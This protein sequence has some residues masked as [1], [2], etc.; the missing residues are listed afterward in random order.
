MIIQ[1]ELQRCAEKARWDVQDAEEWTRWLREIPTIQFPSYWFVRM[2]PPFNGAIVRFR[3]SLDGD[4]EHEAS[5][6]LD[7]YDRIGCFGAPYWEVYPYGDD[8]GRVAMTDVAG[9]MEMLIVAVKQ[10]YEQ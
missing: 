4:R 2:S 8:V 5:V 7:C 6:Y 10:A 1:T 9:L 3:V